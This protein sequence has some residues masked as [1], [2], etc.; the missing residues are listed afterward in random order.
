MNHIAKWN[1]GGSSVIFGGKIL[2]V[3]E[4]IS[5]NVK[6]CQYFY[7]M[8]DFNFVK[9]TEKNFVLTLT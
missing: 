2:Q 9:M 7:Q 3:H 1:K 5:I 6:C 4:P 8:L